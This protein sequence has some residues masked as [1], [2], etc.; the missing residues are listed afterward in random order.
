M[1]GSFLRRFLIGSSIWLATQLPSYAGPCEDQLSVPWRNSIHSG[2]LPA[3]SAIDIKSDGT[4]GAGNANSVI[5]RSFHNVFQGSQWTL[6]TTDYVEF[7]TPRDY[8]A[9]RD[10][11]G[12]P[13]AAISISEKAATLIRIFD[14]PIYQNRFVF[15]K[16]AKE[17]IR[18]STVKKIYIITTVGTRFPISEESLSALRELLGSSVTSPS[19]IKT[20]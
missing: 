4:L 7:F 17:L 10:C 8:G 5:D 2:R 11:E 3:N 12:A 19:V 1:I 13:F 14:G 9:Y 15:T 6:L 20:N 18:N 16:E